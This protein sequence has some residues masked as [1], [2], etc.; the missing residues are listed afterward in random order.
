MCYWA[1]MSIAGLGAVAVWLFVAGTPALAAEPLTPEETVRRYLQA[2][3][4]RKFDDAYGLVSKAMRGG[5]EREVWVKESEVFSASAEVK[6]FSFSVH[7]G[8]VEG[9]KAY[10]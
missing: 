1:R 9:D 2:L 6:I 3:K 5:K 10:V 7:P 4:D 8:K